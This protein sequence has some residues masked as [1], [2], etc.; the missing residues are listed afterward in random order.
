MTTLGDKT[1]FRQLTVEEY[2]DV[3][4]TRSRTL[5]KITGMK[6]ACQDECERWK[7]DFEQ[8]SIAYAKVY[9]E[10]QALK[11]GLEATERP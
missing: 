1:M 4:D 10:L 11:Q 6:E 9:E 2:V 5:R 8:K 3:L 7:A